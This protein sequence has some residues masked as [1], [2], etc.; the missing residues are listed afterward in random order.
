MK[1]PDI[2][3]LDK[4][5]SSL[6]YLLKVNDLKFEIIKRICCLSNGEIAKIRLINYMIIY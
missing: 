4:N 6:L 5:L 3:P 1:N 2:I